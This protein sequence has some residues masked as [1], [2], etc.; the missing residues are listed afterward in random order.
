M[1]AELTMAIDSF[2]MRRARLAK[3]G[4]V[5][6]TDY[7]EMPDGAYRERFD[8]EDGRRIDV[9]VDIACLLRMRF[10]LNVGEARIEEADR[11]LSEALGVDVRGQKSVTAERP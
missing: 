6:I 11:V 2:D 1:S 4:I 9:D 5:R 8:F 7:G 10:R 3:F